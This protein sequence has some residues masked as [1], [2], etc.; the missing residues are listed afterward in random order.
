MDKLRILVLV[1]DPGLN[2]SLADLLRLGGLEV[3]GSALPAPRGGEHVDL[4]IAARDSWPAPWTLP[5]L[6]SRF[7]QV[8]CLLL[9]GSPVSG[10]YAAAGFKRGYFLALPASGRRIADMVRSLLP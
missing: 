3:I 8:P 9:S 5:M 7:R 10:P 4:V 1:G 6:K 2:S